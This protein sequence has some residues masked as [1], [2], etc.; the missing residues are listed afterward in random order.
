MVPGTHL[1]AKRPRWSPPAVPESSG[2]QAAPGVRRWLLARTGIPLRGALRDL[3]GPA[4][5]CAPRQCPRE[6]RGRALR[7]AGN[8][9]ESCL[10]SWR[11]SY[12][13]AQLPQQPGLGEA[14]I[15][16][17]GPRGNVQDRDDFLF[18]QSAEVTQLDDFGLSRRHLGERGQGLV[19][20]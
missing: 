10:W 20:S 15:A 7:S 3:P 12:G 13:T 4:G 8:A 18:R 9:P 14:P 16:L 19:E 2:S 5:P 11:S 6:P 1:K 17:D